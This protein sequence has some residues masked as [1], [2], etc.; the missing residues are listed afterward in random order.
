MNLRF[1]VRVPDAALAERVIAEVWAAGS[2]GVEDEGTILRVY[3][4]GGAA[5]NVRAAARGSQA[6]A[7]SLLIGSYMPPK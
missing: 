6:R 4:P 5:A 2:T 7:P 1:E 3:A